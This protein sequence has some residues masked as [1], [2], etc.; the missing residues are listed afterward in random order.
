MFPL[1]HS[2]LRQTFLYRTQKLTSCKIYTGHIDPIIRDFAPKLLTKQP[3]FAFLPQQICVL[4]QPS[5]FYTSLLHL[6]R[7]A[8]HRVFISSLYVGSEDTEILNTI[9]D[10]LRQKAPLHV[11]FQLDLNRSTRPG[12][13][14]TARLL[15]P[16]LEEFPAR[17]HHAS[18]KDGER[19]MQKYTA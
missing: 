16:L 4:K 3:A 14:S 19:G 1:S 18:M 2:F 12:S 10:V 17:F 11:Y 13:T 9:V 8:E 7:R 5:E 15:L 6:I